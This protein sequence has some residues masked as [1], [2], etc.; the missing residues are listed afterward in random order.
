MSTIGTSKKTLADISA[1]FHN[2]ALI[3]VAEVLT[4]QNEILSDIPWVEGNEIFGH[5]YSIRSAKPTGSYRK[6]NEG[7]DRSAG[8]TQPGLESMGML[9]DWSEQDAKLVDS[10]P[11]PQGFR[12]Q[13]DSA[14]IEGMRDTFASTLMNGNAAISPEEM[15]GFATRLNSLA[16]ESANGVPNVIGASGTGNDTTSIY[17]IQWGVRKAYMFYPKGSSGG[18]SMKAYDKTPIKD[19]AGKLYDAYRTHFQWDHGLVVEDTRC[20]Q[21]IANIEASGASNIFD[22]DDLITAINR[23]PDGGRGAAIYC[24]A[25]IKTQMDIAAAAKANVNYTSG[26]QFGTPVLNFRGIPIRQVDAILDTETA[27]S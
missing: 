17:V 14:H 3:P 9:E 26:E 8:R 4:N 15:N 19:A 13:E 25:T 12:F 21:R 2:G 16:S 27:I 11:N 24:N 5:R 1:S 6:L 10:N 7:V 18:L 20:T 23:L 22:P